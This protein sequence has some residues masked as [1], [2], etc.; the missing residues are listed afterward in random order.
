VNIGG[1]SAANHTRMVGNVI[2]DTNSTK[3][4]SPRQDGWGDGRLL[5]LAA[6]EA[7]L[8]GQAACNDLRTAIIV[9]ECL[10]ICT[11]VCMV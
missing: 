4:L 8:I 2:P 6:V 3:S 10:P 9:M 1:F 5:N 7:D 11:I